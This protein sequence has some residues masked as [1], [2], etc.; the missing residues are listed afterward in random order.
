MINFNDFKKIDL[1]IAKIFEVENIEGSSK[2]L[3]ITIELDKE[4]RQIVSGIQ[5]FYGAQELIGKQIVVVL[6]L[7]PKTI[8][9]IK[10][11]GM[12]LCAESCGGP[13]L[14]VPDRDVDPGSKIT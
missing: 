12:L 4:R 7:E 14:L 13:V 6:N 5:E 8:F 10:S 1:Q 9:G 2:L 3:N 11:H